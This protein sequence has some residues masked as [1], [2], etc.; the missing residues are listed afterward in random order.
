MVAERPVCGEPKQKL[1][2]HIRDVNAG[3]SSVKQVKN[4]LAESSKVASQNNSLRQDPALKATAK[5]E[6]PI[7][8]SES[9][10]GDGT[11]LACQGHTP[12]SRSRHIL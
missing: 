1:G 11:W 7:G 8:S 4:L 5:A 3:M 2:W 10:L 9:C 12:G 6:W